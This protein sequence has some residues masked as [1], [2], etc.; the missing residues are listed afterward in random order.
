MPYQRLNMT[1]IVVSVFNNRMCPDVDVFSGNEFLL[2]GQRM[3]NELQRTDAAR[4]Q[5]TKTSAQGI[6]PWNL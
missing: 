6:E 1:T 5:S 4:Q 2:A 3:A